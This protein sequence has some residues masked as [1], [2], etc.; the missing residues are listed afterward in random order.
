MTTNNYK[1]T[2]FF[3]EYWG[4][5]RQSGDQAISDSM[6]FIAGAD[7][8]HDFNEGNASRVAPYTTIYAYEPQALNTLFGIQNTK[9]A[10]TLTPVIQTAA[11][12]YKMTNITTSSVENATIRAFELKYPERFYTNNTRVVVSYRQVRDLIATLY[13]VDKY[14]TNTKATDL[15]NASDS[16]TK[17][18]YPGIE[19]V[20]QLSI[21][22][23]ST[24]DINTVIFAAGQKLYNT[25]NQCAILEID[26]AEED[27]WDRD[28]SEIQKSHI[29]IFLLNFFFPPASEAEPADNSTYPTYIT[30]D[31]GSNA[32]TTVFR[33]LTQV[34]NMVSPL[35]IADSATT[36]NHMSGRNYYIFPTNNPGNTEYKYRSNIMTG[37]KSELIIT[38][39]SNS[40]STYSH[41][42]RFDFNI[43]ATFIAENN[44]TITNTYD[45]RN[46]TSGPGVNYISALIDSVSSPQNISD[47]YPVPRLEGV[48][49]INSFIQALSKNTQI[50]DQTIAEILFDWKRSGDWEQCNAAKIA[51]VM[52]TSPTQGRTVLATIDRLC[53]LYSRMLK[54]NTILHHGLRMVLYRFPAT[55]MNKEALIKQRLDE[56][57]IDVIQRAEFIQGVANKQL[58]LVNPAIDSAITSLNSIVKNTT[59]SFNIL[60]LSKKT[61][62]PFGTYLAKQL[63]QKTIDDLTEANKNIST[64]STI[65]AKFQSTTTESTPGILQK[66]NETS[67]YHTSVNIDKIITAVD[68]LLA[69]IPDANAEPHDT[70]K[71]TYIATLYALTYFTT[72]IKNLYVYDVLTQRIS[73]KLGDY[74]SCILL[75]K[76]FGRTVSL[77]NIDTMIPVIQKISIFNEKE[78][79]FGKGGYGYYDYN[80]I[81]TIVKGIDKVKDFD[82]KSRRSNLNSLY[83]MLEKFGFFDALRKVADILPSSIQNI[84]SKEDE[85][86]TPGD[87]KPGD[88]DMDIAVDSKPVSVSVSDIFTQILHTPYY[89]TTP[90]TETQA[91]MSDYSA[92]NIKY[93]DTIQPLI[94]KLQIFKPNGGDLRGGDNIE[95]MT[96]QLFLPIHTKL[97]TQYLLE[98]FEEIKSGVYHQYD[99]IVRDF[100]DG[101]GYSTPSSQPSAQ[102]PPPPPSQS[103]PPSPQNTQP[104]DSEKARY[105]YNALFNYI[106]K[107]MDFYNSNSTIITQSKT[108]IGLIQQYATFYFVVMTA[109]IIMF[110]PVSSLTREFFIS[111]IN[112]NLSNFLSVKKYTS[113][114]N[115]QIITIIENYTDAVQLNG[116]INIRNYSSS[117]LSNLQQSESSRTELVYTLFIIYNEI[118]Q[119]QRNIIAIEEVV[120]SQKY[121]KEA[122]G[123][124]EGIS[125]ITTIS[126]ETSRL[127]ENAELTR[128]ISPN[129][130]NDKKNIIDQIIYLT[131]VKIPS[132]D[133]ITPSSLLYKT[134]SDSYITN[135]RQIRNIFMLILANK[136]G[137]SSSLEKLL[138][139]V[140]TAT[141]FYENTT[142]RK[143]SLSTSELP[144]PPPNIGGRPRT[145]RRPPTGLLLTRRRSLPRNRKR[146]NSRWRAN[147]N[148][149]RRNRR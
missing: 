100:L 121:K 58:A 148:R 45:F 72:R 91:K 123:Y 52:D 74:E 127:T 4:D 149:T 27:D 42:T 55:E 16:M 143:R 85:I 20:E 18:P 126:T 10:N 130:F 105:L 129:T 68:G 30:F 35:N 61:V 135:Y 32:P 13:G 132:N 128:E 46:F 136:S 73:E 119:R 87:T 53:S 93:K 79:V 37:T 71:P 40:N 70:T 57:K 145:N 114:F 97:H 60:S 11:S 98:F 41:S 28:F 107:V 15:Q 44:T 118:L 12:K 34:M 86:R 122:F 8:I 14:N 49:R 63:I 56:K 92:L 29:G 26:M 62:Y 109:V 21:T 125:S 25:I 67:E 95:K 65:T 96:P 89:E 124:T 141:Y 146:S 142:N 9:T 94:E 38:P 139:W 104:P 17:N 2:D 131:T 64:L 7:T 133:T 134:E 147:K 6:K 120:K 59:I 102:M 23:T 83:D 82:V 36:A 90:S 108:D 75:S 84:A 76:I 54:Q 31:A 48:L 106:D 39:N 115:T 140:D 113:F 33:T 43:K 24:P 19:Q 69:L 5:V 80:A 138:G 3:L 78:S 88:T 22:N 99:T 111:E 116:L 137:N 66:I 112:H 50:Q 144:P 77:E 103:P 117:I 81:E 51:N 101:T 110:N 1:N 47:T